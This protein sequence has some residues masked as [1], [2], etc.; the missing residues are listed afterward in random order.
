LTTL[1][2]Y[3]TPA[4]LAQPM[5][6]K[7]KQVFEVDHSIL[8]DVGN[9]HYRRLPYLLELPIAPTGHTPYPH[10]GD[11]MFP[12]HSR[13]NS[14]FALRRAQAMGKSA[15]IDTEKH[16]SLQI[17]LFWGGRNETGDSEF[18]R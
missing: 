14:I 7:D 9:G 4:R 17:V 18:Y 5:F 8:I 11:T 3:L 12:S 6:C 13:A 10:Q 15:V 2:S 16:G 1:L